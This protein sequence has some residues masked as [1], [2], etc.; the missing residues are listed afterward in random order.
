MGTKSHISKALPASIMT[1]GIG[2]I[3][4]QRA[5]FRTGCVYLNSPGHFLYVF[6]ALEYSGWQIPASRTAQMRFGDSL[7]PYSVLFCSISYGNLGL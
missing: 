4:L 3:V 1:K 7:L 5:A 6:P 2:L